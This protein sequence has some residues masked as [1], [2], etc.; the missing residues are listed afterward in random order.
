MIQTFL[1][2]GQ[3]NMAGRGP[4]DEVPPIVNSD[5]QM[6]RDGLWM[7]A[8]EPLHT[9]KPAM[10]GIGPGMSFADAL[11]RRHGGTIGLIP[12]AFGGTAL[13]E[14]QPGEPLFT[15]AV[16]ATRTA[17]LAGGVLRGILWHQ[18]ESD[19]D[20][21]EDAERYD[22]GFWS[23]YHPLTEQ[24]GGKEVPFLIGE[25]GDFLA[26]YAPGCGFYRITNQKLKEIADSDPAIEWVPATGLTDRGDSL[27]FDAR[28]Q[29]VFGLRYAD[30]WE[31]AAARLGIT[32]T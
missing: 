17:Q 22:T 5:V 8:S 25:L 3:S 10:A 29:R 15:A 20:T 2:I 9:D 32:L 12:C 31:Q 23:M 27:H 1:L 16:Q 11:Q 13:R 28:S 24:I 18:G 30:A 19:S 26:N 14:W 7:P 6:F 4:L 21:R